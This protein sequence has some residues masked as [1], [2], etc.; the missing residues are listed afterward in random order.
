MIQRKPMSPID[1]GLVGAASFLIAVL[2][3]VGGA[4]VGFTGWS[5][6]AAGAGA[7]GAASIV[8]LGLRSWTDR[9]EAV[10]AMISCPPEESRLDDA[11]ERVLQAASAA[12]ED[13]LARSLRIVDAFWHAGQDEI[14]EAIL[15]RARVD[16]LEVPP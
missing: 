6:V 3:A 5:L 11:L 16:Y 10:G 13:S 8:L 1:R 9:R 2:T 4:A 12:G 14:V 7:A 15:R